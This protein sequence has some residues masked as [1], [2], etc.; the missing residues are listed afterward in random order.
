MTSLRR[1]SLWA[2][3]VG[4]CS[5]F[6]ADTTFLINHC[7]DSASLDLFSFRITSTPPSGRRRG[8]SA[9]LVRNSF[10]PRKAILSFLHDLN[11]PICSIGLKWKSEGRWQSMM[12]ILDIALSTDSNS[13]P[14]LFRV[15]TCDFPL[16]HPQA[17]PGVSY[18]SI[19]NLHQ[20]R[21]PRSASAPR[22][23]LGT[24]P[25]ERPLVFGALQPSHHSSHKAQSRNVE[26]L[27]RSLVL[28]AS[29]SK[30][31]RCE[32]VCALRGGPGPPWIWGTSWPPRSD[33][34]GALH[35]D[36]SPP[37]WTAESWDSEDVPIPR[38]STTSTRIESSILNWTQGERSV[39]GR[40][41]H[42]Q[43][44]LRK[45]PS[46]ASTAYRG[47][48]GDDHSNV[49]FE[50]LLNFPL[51]V[52]TPARGNRSASRRRAPEE[53]SPCVADRWS[54]Q[55]A[56]GPTVLEVVG[57]RGVLMRATLYNRPRIA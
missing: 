36:N 40:Y 15:K 30:P 19:R 13:T 37:A 43:G 9:G 12:Y 38:K 5:R 44:A 22:T 14:C 23:E 10:T 52:L 42:A 46:R 45:L 2:A 53:E 35:V 25:G 17:S 29:A 28:Q 48:H 54:I 4:L 49:T 27:A 6:C 39:G 51:D 50:A 34:R 3:T 32:I 21:G 11:N 56:R 1:R 8:R 41:S 31:S 16:T 55:R 26:I 33:Q 57:W 18:L 24:L 20:L 47:R 7:T